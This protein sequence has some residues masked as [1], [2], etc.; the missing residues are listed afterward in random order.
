MDR[1]VKVR[2]NR[3]ELAE[4]DFRIREFGIA[5]CFS[6]I[7][8]GNIYSFLEMPAPIDED[9]LR[10]YLATKLPPYAL[11]SRFAY[12]SRLPRNHNDKI[13]AIEL[14]RSLGTLSSE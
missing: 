6:I 4:V 1:Q 5:N 7:H 13:D 10:N 8:E 12:K 9:A 14:E 2:G 11:P 3:V